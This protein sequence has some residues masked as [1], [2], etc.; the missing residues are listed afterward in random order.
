MTRLRPAP[1]YPQS[2]SFAM[3]R[4]PRRGTAPVW[5]AMLALLALAVA[6]ASTEV[7]AAPIVSRAGA[8]VACPDCGRVVSVESIDTAGKPTG[9]G[10]IMGGVVG[11]LVG[12]EL[13]RRHDDGAP[14]AVLGA[15][16]GGFIGHHIEKRVRT[17][18]TFE[19]TVRMDDG[20]HKVL[21]QT[22]PVEV[23]QVVVVRGEVARPLDTARGSAPE[24]SPRATRPTEL[25][26]PTHQI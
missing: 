24:G 7:H 9:M 5:A 21:T 18:T 11:G 26:S 14:L 4:K 1:P 22:E 15:I 10:A 3:A 19:V 25:P 8:D 13:S 6:A 23:G 12:R 2:G 16:G 20:R 17:R